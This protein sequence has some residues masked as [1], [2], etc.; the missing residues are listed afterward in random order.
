MKSEWEHIGNIKLYGI[1][2]YYTVRMRVI[3]G[4]IVNNRCIL[5]PMLDSMVFIPDANH[6]WV[7]EK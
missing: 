2:C 7:I 6:E 1:Y 5:S 4:W 3:G